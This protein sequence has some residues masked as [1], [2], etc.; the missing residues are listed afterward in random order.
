MQEMRHK[1]ATRYGFDPVKNYILRCISYSFLFFYR[2]LLKIQEIRHKKA[3]PYGFVAR[4]KP[5]ILFYVAFH[6]F[7]CV[8]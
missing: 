4:K 5:G 6:A 2:K 3:S 7:S 1:K 8:L